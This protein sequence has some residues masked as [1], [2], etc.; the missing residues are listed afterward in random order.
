MVKVFPQENLKGSSVASLGNENL[1][2]VKHDSAPLQKEQAEIFYTVTM[3]GLF[4][5]KHGHPD[6]APATAY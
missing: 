3:Q 4:L 2:K 6:M 5:C 1:F